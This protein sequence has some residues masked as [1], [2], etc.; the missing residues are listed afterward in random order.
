MR[1]LLRVLAIGFA[2]VIALLAAAAIIEVNNARSIA[3]SSA[4]LVNNQLV[5]ARLLDE[6]ER[7]QGVLNATLYRLSN[8]PDAVNRDRVLADIDQ[9]QNEIHKMVSE[10]RGSPNE[11]VW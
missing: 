11:A 2:A 7:E 1:N 3:A 8:T 4:E 5:T 9:T 6:V 10:A